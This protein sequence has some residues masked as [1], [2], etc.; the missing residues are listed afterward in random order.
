MKKAKSAKK[1]KKLGA[2]KIAPTKPLFV[3][4]Y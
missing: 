1:G 4:P 3:R 2:K